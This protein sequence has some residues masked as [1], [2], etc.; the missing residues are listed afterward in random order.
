VV[1]G[2]RGLSPTDDELLAFARSLL[3]DLGEDFRGEGPLRE[4]LTTHRELWVMLYRVSSSGET[5]PV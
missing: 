3:G 2:E 5:P 1:T 4:T